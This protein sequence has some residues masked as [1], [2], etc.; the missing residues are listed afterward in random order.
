MCGIVGYLRRAG[1]SDERSVG[2]VVLE[3]L[4]ALSTRGP[5]STG[6]AL[7]AAPHGDDQRVR[8]KLGEGDPEPSAEQAV[9]Q[10]VRALTPVRSTARQGECLRLAVDAAPPD[11]L[12]RAILRA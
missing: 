12:E 3:M 7:Y 11:Q 9:L 5:D 1:C 4:C 8:L 10:A 6:V 2:T